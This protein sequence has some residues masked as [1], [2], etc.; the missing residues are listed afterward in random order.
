MLKSRSLIPNKASH[1]A[2]L[3]ALNR[4]QR[5]QRAVKMKENPQNQVH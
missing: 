2:A 3:D 1:L 5:S 4:H